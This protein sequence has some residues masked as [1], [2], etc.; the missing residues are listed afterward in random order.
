MLLPS[1]LPSPAQPSQGL[2]GGLG[3][4]SS[5]IIS[6][7]W[8]KEEEL[9]LG[10]TLGETLRSTVTPGTHIGNWL[11]LVECESHWVVPK[12]WAAAVYGTESPVLRSSSAHPAWEKG[13]V[14]RY[15]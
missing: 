1:F 2:Q 10:E 13:H 11:S 5:S 15:E 7:K 3:W 4:F 6:P 8:P 9:V 12:G 14:L